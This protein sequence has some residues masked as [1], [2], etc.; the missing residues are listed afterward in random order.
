MKNLS[1]KFVFILAFL[2]INQ[3]MDAQRFG[4]IL[5]DAG[6]NVRD[7]V[8]TKVADRVADKL[9]DKLADVIV[10]KFSAR[11]D[12]VLEAA[13]E[14]DTT[15]RDSSV[16]Y[17]EFLNNMDQSEKVSDTY[18]FDL[19]TKQTITEPNG[20]ESFSTNYYTKDGS[21]LGIH[22]DE[23]LV[24]LDSKNKLFVTYNMEDK[25]AFA[26]GDSFMKFG[27]SL[28]S[29]DFIPNY[30]LQ[31]S[32]GSKSILGYDCSLYVGDSHDATYE[33]YVANGFPISME[34]AYDAIGETF[35]DERWDDSM[36]E[37]PGLVLES[38]AIEENGDVIHSLVTEIDKS[39]FSVSKSDFKF[40][41][42][43]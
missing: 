39:S 16:S 8:T 15:G 23:V 26:F 33:M 32:S 4:K 19:S 14:S 41:A 22:T 10:D 34:N 2:F 5:K 43:E 27:S 36:K 9:A 18:T 13:Y 3:S 1:L 37:L 29:D 38:K 6:R 42:P 24:V 11:L 31:S 17:A 21:L 7:G 40:G 30:E 20:K 28:I 25:S 12:S 35:L